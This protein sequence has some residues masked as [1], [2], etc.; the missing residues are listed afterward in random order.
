VD[1]WSLGI[2]TFE[3]IT[4]YPPFKDK[5]S[6]WKKSGWKKDNFWKWNV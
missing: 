4:G 3:L 2:L 1:V 5:I 6:E